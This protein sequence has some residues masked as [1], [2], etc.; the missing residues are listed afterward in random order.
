M[1][2]RIRTTQEDEVDLGSLPSPRFP[3]T[4]K[5]QSKIKLEK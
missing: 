3:K 5:P 4:P 1:G 2:L